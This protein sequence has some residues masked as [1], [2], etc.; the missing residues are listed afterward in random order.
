MEATDEGEVV[1]RSL[2][3][4]PRA[5]EEL[6]GIYERVVYTVAVRMTGDRDQ[7]RDITQTVF[8]KVFRALAS[9]DPRRRFFS[10]I[11]RIAVHESIDWLRSRRHEELLDPSREDPGE[12]PDER[13]ERRERADQVQAA[14]MEM[15]EDDR[16]LLVLRHWL[17]RSLAE[18]GET[19]GVPERTVKSRLFEARRRMGRILRRRGVH[20]A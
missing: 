3:G 4:D 19:L 15:G 18:I 16:Q 11:Y 9:F 8:V 7:A 2:A 10:W 12:R 14:L 17:D 5:R 6:V 1:R 20:Q 13:A